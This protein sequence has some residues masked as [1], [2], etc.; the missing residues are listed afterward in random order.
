MLDWNFED[1]DNPSDSQSAYTLR[2]RIGTG[3]YDYWNGTSWQASEDG[4]TKIASAITNFTLPVSWG[5]DSDPKHYYSIKTWDAADFGPSPWSDELAVIPSA[6]DNPTITAPLTTV[7]G[8][9]A[10][11]TWTVATQTKFQV[12]IYEDDGGLTGATI[13]DS[14]VITSTDQFYVQAF[15]V[16]NVTRWIGVTT[17]NDEGLKSD[18]DFEDVTVDYAPPVTPILN[19]SVLTDPPGILIDVVNRNSNLLSVDTA[20]LEASIGDWAQGDGAPT[21]T[22]ETATPMSLASYLRVES[23]TTGSTTAITPTGLGGFAVVGSTTYH[24]RTLARFDNTDT[25][26]VTISWYDS[27]G[28]FISESVIDNTTA[29]T[30]GQLVTISGTAASPANAEFAAVEIGTTSAGASG[31]GYEFDDIGV[32]EDETDTSFRVGISPDTN[33]LFRRAQPVIIDSQAATAQEGQLGDETYDFDTPW[34]EYGIRGPAAGTQYRGAAQ[35]YIARN[36]FAVSS[37]KVGLD[38]VGTITSGNIELALVEGDV[39]E[40]RVLETVAIDATTLDPQGAVEEFV[41]T[42]PHVLR[43]GVTYWFRLDYTVTDIVNYPRVFSYYKGWEKKT[44]G[45]ADSLLYVKSTSN[46]W[47]VAWDNN[48]DMFAEVWGYPVEPN[49]D[50]SE[51]R[52]VEDFALNASHADRSVASDHEYEYRV[53]STLLSNGSISESEWTA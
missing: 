11:V 39:D 37:V 48:E 50:Y 16:N 32:W 19:L 34:F 2:R 35:K 45:I 3:S 29:M 1:P 7:T 20:N 44:T 36:A 21:L 17:W 40:G 13:D 52:I 51:T 42:S 15:P 38:Q 12:K 27:G 26:H 18:E 33:E 10:T 8:G 31:R 28:T 46:V 9:N 53:R 49:F 22:V 41:F 5:L 4:T 24:V 14:G 6:K 43:E 25:I 23:T 47:E 30:S